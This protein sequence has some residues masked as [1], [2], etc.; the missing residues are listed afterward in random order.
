MQARGTT[1]LYRGRQSQD[2]AILTET[3]RLFARARHSFGT[4]GSQVLG[5]A[6]G[7]WGDPKL[8]SNPAHAGAAAP[9]WEGHI[10]VCGGMDSLMQLLVPMRASTSKTIVLLNETK[11]PDHEWAHIRDHIGNVEFVVGSPLDADDLTRCDIKTASVILIRSYSLKKDATLSDEDMKELQ[12][13]IDLRGIFAVCFIE[14]SY[15][16]R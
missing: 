8:D 16:C 5:S 4:S 15:S 7:I 13:E 11:L 3:P 12:E 1:F 10:I 2:K 6:L 14:A 9:T